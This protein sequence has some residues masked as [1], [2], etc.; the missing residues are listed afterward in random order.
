MA[1][2]NINPISHRH[3]PRTTITI[4][5]QIAGLFG[6]FSRLDDGLRLGGTIPS[7][8]GLSG[9][10]WFGRKR[11][12]IGQ[13]DV[14]RWLGCCMRLRPRRRLLIRRGGW[15][16]ASCFLWL[17]AIHGLGWMFRKIGS[18][19]FARSLSDWKDWQTNDLI[20]FHRYGVHR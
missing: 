18:R 15:H 19:T 9:S 7:E 1:Q 14:W 12:L 5:G 13:A 6:G 3:N 11:I 2:W 4:H 10:D 16:C 20:W 17:G 8:V